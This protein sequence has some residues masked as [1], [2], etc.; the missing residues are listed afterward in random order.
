MIQI[1]RLRQSCTSLEESRLTGSVV[2]NIQGN[3][4]LALAELLSNSGSSHWM[5]AGIAIRMAQI[6]R[7]NKEY[8]QK[9]DIQEQEMRR[10]TFWACLLMDRSLAYILNKPRTLSLANVDIALPLPDVSIAWQEQRKGHTLASLSS[11]NGY[12]S[13]IGIVP[14]FIKS[15]CLWSDMADQNICHRRLTDNRSPLDPMSDISRAC[16]AL[17]TESLSLPMH[18]QWSE[19]N[20]LIH[21]DLGQGRMFVSLHAL[22][23]S[24][25]CIGYQCYL[26]QLDGCSLLRDHVDGAGL[27]L[28]HREPSLISICVTNAMAL[29]DVVTL[30]LS[31]EDAD[32]ANSLETTWFAF[33]A[34]PAAN[35]CLWLQYAG[36]KEFGDQHTIEKA[37]QFL[38]TIKSLLTSLSGQWRIAHEWLATLKTMEATYRAAY[39]GEVPQESEIAEM[40]PDSGEWASPR[41]YR[42][43]P[44]DGCPP[45]DWR[46]NLYLALRMITTE[47]T[48]EELGSVWMYLAGGWCEDLPESLVSSVG[49][50]SREVDLSWDC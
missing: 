4:V 45:V 8:Q 22:L 18:L 35:I 30:I 39:L 9:H 27:S 20:Y 5:Y 21:R 40:L 49:M 25:Q 41:G 2:Q 47:S 7:L 26:P 28:L 1:V 31:K 48:L 15:V 42:P 6:M 11:F 10:R 37:K 50:G 17:Q 14:Y 3:L 23:H 38:E 43:R 12:P 34:L 29:Y 13:E 44:G 36:D 24:A 46:Q 32:D 19:K 16:E 33:A